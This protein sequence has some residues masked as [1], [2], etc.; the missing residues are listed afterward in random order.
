MGV[1]VETLPSNTPS[2]VHVVMALLSMATL[3]QLR[4]R[5]PVAHDLKVLLAM[6]IEL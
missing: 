3:L 2:L 5:M 6:R 4:N 1:L